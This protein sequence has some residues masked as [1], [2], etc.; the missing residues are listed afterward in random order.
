MDQTKT[1]VVE[2]GCRS[3]YAFNKTK[4]IRVWYNKCVSKICLIFHPSVSIA[5]V[6]PSSQYSFVIFNK[7]LYNEIEFV[8]LKLTGEVNKLTN[9]I[10]INSR[11]I[12][13]TMFVFK[14]KRF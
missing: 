10:S 7:P 12:N 6:L 9:K 13:K 3:F 1:E 11:F 5:G 14:K 8:D 2:H 4:K